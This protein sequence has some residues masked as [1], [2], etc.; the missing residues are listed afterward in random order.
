M[1]INDLQN[2][3][4]SI[5]SDAQFAKFDTSYS[6]CD[7][8]RQSM[9]IRLVLEYI[10]HSDSNSMNNNKLND[11]DTMF[12]RIVRILHGNYLLINLSILTGYSDS[13]SVAQHII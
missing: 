9:D 4:R 13:L 6:S 1:S 3:Q 8:C 7:G 11:C 10:I 12:G 2:Q 5:D